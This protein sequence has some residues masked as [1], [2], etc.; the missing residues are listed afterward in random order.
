[1]PGGFHKD[2]KGNSAAPPFRRSAILQS[3][4]L[5]PIVGRSVQ[6]LDPLAVTQGVRCE[7]DVVR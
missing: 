4:D 5:R 2:D 7:G 6:E 3:V 1:M